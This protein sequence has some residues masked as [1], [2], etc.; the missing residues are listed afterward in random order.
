MFELQS[1]N[2][3]EHLAETLETLE[4]SEPSQ[5]IALLSKASYSFLQLKSGDYNHRAKI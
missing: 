1:M 3:L 5:G 4:S 2:T